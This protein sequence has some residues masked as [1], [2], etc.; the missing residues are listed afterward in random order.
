MVWVI[1]NFSPVIEFLFLSNQGLGCAIK[2]REIIPSTEFLSQLARNLIQNFEDSSSMLF[3]SAFLKSRVLRGFGLL[4]TGL[5]SESTTNIPSWSDNPGITET[6][7]MREILFVKQISNTRPCL[8][9]LVWT[10]VREFSLIRSISLELAARS[11]APGLNRP[12]GQ[13]ISPQLKSPVIITLE[14]SDLIWF[15][16]FCRSL[17]GAAPLSGDL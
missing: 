8:V 11:L 4:K 2:P 6:L 12:S 3:Q 13:S 9:G 7:L 10:L 16:E 15:R 1:R 17:S 14:F 5:I